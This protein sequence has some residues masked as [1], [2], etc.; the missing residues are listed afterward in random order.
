MKAFNFSCKCL[1]VSSII[2]IILGIYTAFCKNTPLFIPIDLFMNPIFWK[3]GIIDSGTMSFSGFMYSVWGSTILIW[4]I[5]LYLIVKFAFRKK[6][7]WAW[8]GIF[9][10]AIV[11]FPIDT[12]YSIYYKVYFNAAGNFILLLLIL[13]PLIMTRDIIK[14]TK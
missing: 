14:K 2:L 11:W 8:W 9:I 6:E 4:G 5:L 1:Q 10:C 12:G 13:I 3:N 7:V